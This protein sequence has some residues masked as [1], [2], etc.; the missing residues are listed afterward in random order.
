VGLR[1]S[2]LRLLALLLLSALLPG[3]LL[4]R[5]VE[6]SRYPLEIQILSSEFVPLDEEA[7]FPADC[8]LKHYSKACATAKT[9]A[10]TSVIRMVDSWA[11]EYTLRCE[12]DVHWSNCSPLPE[13]EKFKGR[14]HKNGYTIVYSDPSGEEAPHFYPFP[15]KPGKA[16]KSQTEAEREAVAQPSPAEMDT[17]PVET[18]PAEGGTEP[19]APAAATL[20]EAVPE[21]MI[22]CRFSSTP[23]GAEI[24]IDGSYVGNTPSEIGLAPGAHSIVISMPGY[25]E[26]KRDLHITP[27][28][29]VNVTARLLQLDQ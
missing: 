25:G 17:E 10:G 21:E 29:T 27:A 20:E 12:P 13:N 23:D 7:E 4:A 26:W 22:R 14:K 19:V 1:T 11:R 2:F 9:P 3:T 15:V 18:A 24:N 8:D 6:D 5:W 16:K 28:S